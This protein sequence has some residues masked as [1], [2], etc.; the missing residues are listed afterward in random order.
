MAVKE[1]NTLSTHSFSPL[2]H[3]RKG[4]NQGSELG[5]SGLST[6]N[7]A[8]YYYYL[9]IYKT[10]IQTNLKPQYFLT[11]LKKVSQGYQRVGNFQDTKMR[12]AT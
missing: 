2:T 9:Y 4:L 8:S 7:N 6:E 10:L 3:K 1:S 12:E 5:F 11:L